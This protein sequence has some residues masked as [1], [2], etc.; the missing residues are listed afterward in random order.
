HRDVG[1]AQRAADAQAVALQLPGA[2]GTHQEA[3]L[4]ARLRQAAAEVAA[5]AAG[6]EHQ[7]AHQLRSP[8]PRLS[9]HSDSPPRAATKNSIS[10][11]AIHSGTSLVP[12]R[13]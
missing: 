9:S 3:D 11:Y 13:P 8:T 4:G 5:G 6:T 12:S 10:A 2:R 1:V 7:H